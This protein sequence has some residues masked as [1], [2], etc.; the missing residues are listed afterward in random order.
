MCMCVSMCVC[1]CVNLCEFV[2]V[3]VRVCEYV[4]EC[5]RVCDSVN[6]SK[7]V[8]QVCIH[9]SMYGKSVSEVQPQWFLPKQNIS[10]LGYTHRN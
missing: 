9:A 2:C 3:C 4:C 5:L 10:C 1:M 7:C 6:V 8:A